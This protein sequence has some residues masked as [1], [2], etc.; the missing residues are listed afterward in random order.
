MS[1]ADTRL[2][3]VCLPDG[4]TPGTL[5]ADAVNRCLPVSGRGCPA[6]ISLAGHFAYR[7]RRVSKLVEPWQYRASGGPVRLLDLSAMR[8]DWHAQAWQRWQLWSHVVAH[9]PI[10]RPFWV[11]ARKH[12]DN[13]RRYPITRAQQDYLAQPRI[14]AM[15]MHNALATAGQLLLPT[16][17]LEAFQAGPEQYCGLG[18]LQAVPGSA[19]IDPDG[20]YHTAASGR[21]ADHVAYL[22]AANHHIDRLGRTAAL[23]ALAVS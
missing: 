21:L 10:A 16:N 3:V 18:W 14:I 7:T 4:G 17:E 15:R 8:A 2:V 19:F 6:D 5:V 12:Q 11:F 23:V 9:L 13:P 22:A 20:G 1:T